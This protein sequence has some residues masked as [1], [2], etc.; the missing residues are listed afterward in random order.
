MKGQDLLLLLKLVSLERQAQ[1][2][3]DRPIDRSP[4]DW[5]GWSDFTEERHVA[6]PLPLEGVYSVRA[7][8]QETG[9]SK[10]EVSGALRRCFQSGLAREDRRTGTPTANTKALWEVL[11]FGARY[12]FPVSP[13]PLV[14]GIPTAAAAPVLAGRL[15]SAGDTIHVWEDVRGA[16]RGQRIEPLYRT[17]PRAVRRDPDLYAML[18]LVD[19]IRLGGERETALA[20]KLLAERLGRSDG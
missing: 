18:A 10:S 6:E 2:A 16:A 4:N 9:I 1:R 3:G 11:A 12:V 15:M 8:E 7:L 20:R 19:S 14:S 5:R 13:G 17:V